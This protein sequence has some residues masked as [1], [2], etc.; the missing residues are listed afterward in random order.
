MRNLFSPFQ[1]HPT[2][3]VTWSEMRLE[4]LLRFPT[5]NESS[6]DNHDEM[7]KC[8]LSIVPAVCRG[9]ARGMPAPAMAARDVRPRLAM[10]ESN[11][12]QVLPCLDEPQFRSKFNLAVEVSGVPPGPLCH[13]MARASCLVQPSGP[14]CCP[15]VRALT[16]SALVSACPAPEQHCT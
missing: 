3:K 14:E 10:Q 6:R 13:G 2:S 1:N 9:T 5:I 8:Q 12:R 4:K 16:R 7:P 11:A 15:V